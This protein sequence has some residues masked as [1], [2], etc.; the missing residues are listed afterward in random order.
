[1]DIFALLKQD[2][3]E[4]RGLIKKL[5]ALDDLDISQKEQVFHKINKELTAHSRAEEH[6]LYSRLEE[7]ESTRGISLEAEEEHELVDHLLA[8]LH[9]LPVTDYRWNSVVN[10][11]KE[12][13]NH[14]I[15]GEEGEMFSKA[16]RVLTREDLLS[17][18]EE[19]KGEKA[20]LL[21]KLESPSQLIYSS[22]PDIISTH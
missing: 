19:F 17:A 21:R 10:V 9:G 13:L 12:S 7:H 2:H 18:A 3:G 8:K 4:V 6:A 20:E 16:K 14:H 5:Q 15:E 11:L 22:Q 1:M